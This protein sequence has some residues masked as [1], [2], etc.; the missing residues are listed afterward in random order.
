MRKLAILAVLASTAMATPALARNDA[1]YIGAEGGGMLVEKADYRIDNVL[2]QSK[3]KV[4]F[5]VDGII[6]YDF[7]P[8]R[9]EGEV[10]YKQA[11]LKSI[12][13]Q[14]VND[15]FGRTSVLSFMVNGLLDFGSDDGLSGFVGGGAGVGRVKLGNY[16]IRTQGTLTDDSDTGFA[17]Q[18]I[19]G[20]RYPVTTNVD[21]GLKYRFFNENRVDLINTDG[22]SQRTRFRSHS[23]LASLIYNFGEPAAPPPPP[24]PPPPAP[25]PAPPPPPVAAVCTPGPYIVFFEWNK[26]DITAEAASILDNAVTAYG[27]CGQAQVMLAGYT[28][29]SGTPKYNL[30]LSQRRADAVSAYVSS[31]GVPAGVITSKAFG[32]TNLRVQ[33]ADGVRE[34]QNRRVEI[35]YGPGSGN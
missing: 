1:W 16:G 17:Y 2:A 26:S 3:Q 13:T 15:S 34:L 12:S 14:G 25:E 28:D 11:I 5:D 32:E 4:G 33:T 10:G 21:V 30:G 23:L 9:L 8:F 22:V 19:A 31:K 35:T 18:A 6:G 7:G 27:D 20:V 29:T 24:P